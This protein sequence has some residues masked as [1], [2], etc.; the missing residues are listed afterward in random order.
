MGY[1]SKVYICNRHTYENGGV[2]NEVVASMN[3]GKMK[4]D[5]WELF[6]TRLHGDFFGMDGAMSRFEQRDDEDEPKLIDNY[7]DY[8]TYAPLKDV[9]KWCNEAME[10]PA[11][12]MYWRVAVLQKLLEELQGPNM[13]V[14]HYGY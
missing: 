8:L 5:F 10:Q 13:I 2:W 9:L 1:E 3:M 11:Q 7:G 4:H 14:V 12:Y 6:N